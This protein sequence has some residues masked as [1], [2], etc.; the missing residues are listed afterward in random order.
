MKGLFTRGG[1]GEGMAQALMV[2]SHSLSQRRLEE[3]AVLLDS[4]NVLEKA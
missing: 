4:L 2:G 1:Q 3:R